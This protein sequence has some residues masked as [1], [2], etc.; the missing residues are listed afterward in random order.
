M[1][2]EEYVLDIHEINKVLLGKRLNFEETIEIF[3]LLKGV[4]GLT[5]DFNKT[6]YLNN[7]K[8]NELL[9][10]LQNLYKRFASENS[11]IPL[12]SITRAGDS[13]PRNLFEDLDSYP[14][15]FDYSFGNMSSKEVVDSGFESGYVRI[16]NKNSAIV[17]FNGVPLLGPKI[18]RYICELRNISDE[19]VPV[20]TKSSRKIVEAYQ[21]RL[22]KLLEGKLLKPT[23]V[24]HAD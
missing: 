3:D 6:L 21:S 14:L 23:F 11:G 22:F 20:R 5:F 16:E 7:G 17:T 18:S 19:N 8:K 12:E 13:R 1:P 4:K 15:E 24:E 10:S 2:C 9:S